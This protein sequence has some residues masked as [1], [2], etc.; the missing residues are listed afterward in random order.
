MRTLVSIFLLLTFHCRAVAQQDT[1]LQRIYAIAGFGN[2]EY[3]WGGM[4]FT[5]GNL[6]Y[7]EAGIGIKPWGAGTHYSQAHASLGIRI[8]SKH[9]QC[10]HIKISMHAKCFLWQLDNEFNYFA[11]LGAGP[12]LRLAYTRKKRLASSINIGGIYNTVIRYRRKTFT[13][14]G[15]PREFQ[16]SFSIQL[17]YR[18]K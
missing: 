1:S 3:L 5:F 14:A 10:K 4:G 16:P 2:Y 8:R 15:W 7:A 12:E 18:L 13:E 17:N 9:K 6:Y 11:A